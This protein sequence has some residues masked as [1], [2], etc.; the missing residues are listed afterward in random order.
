MKVN[1]RELKAKKQ[2]KQQADI[3][4]KL[5]TVGA[6]RMLLKILYIL[7]FD[8]D[9]RFKNR[10]HAFLKKFADLH[11]KINDLS[12]DRVLASVL[13]KEIEDSGVDLGDMFDDLIE[14]EE[15]EYE[16]DKEQ[17]YGKRCAGK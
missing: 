1:L 13:I 10:L 2:K 3:G 15:V 12:K 4:I 17:E 8:D 16:F 9:Y 14:F 6:K 5:Y 7:R 11:D